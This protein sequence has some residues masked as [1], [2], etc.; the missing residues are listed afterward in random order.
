[1]RQ[2]QKRPCLFLY[3]FQP[4]ITQPALGSAMYTRPANPPLGWLAFDLL[5][6]G[7]GWVSGDLTDGVLS[8]ALST[9]SATGTYVPNQDYKVYSMDNANSAFRLI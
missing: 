6:N 7:N 5:G 1:M 4:S 9:A 3:I 2:G 8:V